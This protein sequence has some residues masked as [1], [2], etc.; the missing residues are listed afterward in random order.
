MG[1][2]WRN[3]C[4]VAF[5][6]VFITAANAAGSTGEKSQVSKGRRLGAEIVRR[7][8]QWRDNLRGPVS[9]HRAEVRRLRR[10]FERILN[11]ANERTTEDGTYRRYRDGASLDTLVLEKP[12]GTRFTIAPRQGLITSKYHSGGVQTQEV[13]HFDR[14]AFR[15]WRNRFED[16]NHDWAEQD[17]T[18]QKGPAKGGLFAKL[19][20]GIGVI[21]NRHEVAGQQEREIARRDYI[22][23]EWSQGKSVTAHGA[24]RASASPRATAPSC[25]T[26]IRRT[27]R[28]LSWSFERLQRASCCG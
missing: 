24:T 9:H 27:L 7:I 3:L 25:S 10:S 12:D 5:S 14:H 1:Q 17:Y 16:E 21:P 4:L 15:R 20:A 22:F 11:G 19:L 28:W 26:P 13:R 2:I 23:R 18:V 6:L 8:R